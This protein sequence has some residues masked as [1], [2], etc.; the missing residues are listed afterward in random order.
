MQISKFKEI[1]NH[2]SSLRPAN[3]TLDVKRRER[4]VISSSDSIFDITEFITKYT[5]I[6]DGKYTLTVY[7]S[8]R[9]S[10]VCK[11]LLQRL[12]NPMYEEYRDISQFGY[13]INCSKRGLDIYLYDDITKN[14]NLVDK[15]EIWSTKSRVFRW[16]LKL[17]KKL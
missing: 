16:I 6:K 10:D 4:C 7:D 12:S 2:F 11:G 1:L 13:L 17:I 15:M 5:L 14:V 8:A 9:L 3:Y